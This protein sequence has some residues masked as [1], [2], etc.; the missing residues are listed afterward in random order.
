[1][2][3]IL[4]TTKDAKYTKEEEYDFVYFASF[5]VVILLDTLPRISGLFPA[6]F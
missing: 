2:P 4:R 5:V 6:S 1:M 3:N